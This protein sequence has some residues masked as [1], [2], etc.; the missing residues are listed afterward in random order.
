[1]SAPKPT[2]A[3]QDFVVGSSVLPLSIQLI[4]SIVLCIAVGQLPTQV[5]NWEYTVAVGVVAAAFSFIGLLI[6]N[7]KRDVYD[8]ILFTAPIFQEVTVG[9]LLAIF[10]FIWWAIGT[11]IITFQAPFNGAGNFNGYFSAWVGFIA[12]VAGLGAVG[13]K[14]YESAKG[15]SGLVGVAAAGVVVLCA[16]GPELQRAA[17]VGGNAIYA[18]VLGI[19]SVVV[20][21]VFLALNHAGKQSDAKSK[22]EFVLMLML[23]IM[24][25]IMACLT[26]FQGPFVVL[27]NGYFGSW[28]GVIAT[29]VATHSALK[30]SRGEGEISG[31]RA[32]P[33]EARANAAAD[34]V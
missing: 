13:H 12:S 34:A 26:T 7:L 15:A 10:L 6:F 22:V 4:A 28:A 25:I 20:A 8:K 29:V 5:Q 14:M 32:N 9:L 2:P 27:G 1:M 23:A 30:E 18:L 21:V 3:L 24:W 31:A 33:P 11:G 19:L 16:A 17:P